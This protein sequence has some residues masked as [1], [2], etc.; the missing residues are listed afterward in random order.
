MNA[1]GLH[2]PCPK[3]K[4]LP[5]FAVDESSPKRGEGVSRSAHTGLVL[6]LLCPVRSRVCSNSL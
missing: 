4:G 6:T 3:S 2:P 5:G 1:A